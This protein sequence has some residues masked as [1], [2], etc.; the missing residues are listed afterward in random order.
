M[1]SNILVPE[2]AHLPVVSSSVPDPFPCVALLF[3]VVCRKHNSDHEQ[4]TDAFWYSMVGESNPQGIC[5]PKHH[6]LLTLS[7]GAP[8]IVEHNSSSGSSSC[9]ENTHTISCCSYPRFMKS[10]YSK[11]TQIAL[12]CNRVSRLWPI[13]SVH[14]C[15]IISRRECPALVVQ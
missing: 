5:F 10:W 8:I 11:R 6:T 12:A 7:G 14:A 13:L 3:R 4:Q 9:C 2:L 1:L 15:K